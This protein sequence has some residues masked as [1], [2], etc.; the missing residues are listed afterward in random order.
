MDALQ[1]FARG[2]FD[3]CRRICIHKKMRNAYFLTRQKKKEKKYQHK[4][5]LQE[6]K[7]T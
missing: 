1:E 2:R 6:K 3:G 5:K 7:V 4:M